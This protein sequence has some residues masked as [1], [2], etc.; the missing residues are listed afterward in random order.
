VVAP[1]EVLVLVVDRMVVDVAD[2]VVVEA[3]AVVVV[4]GLVVVVVWAPALVRTRA[5]RAV[6]ANNAPTQILVLP[7][8][9]S[10]SDHTTGRRS[11]TACTKVVSV[12]YPCLAATTQDRRRARQHDHPR[13]EAADRRLPLTFRRWSTAVA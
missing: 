6:A 2:V 5:L 10:F 3:G 13:R 8:G 11:P 9:F 7:T 12:P 4:V 1:R